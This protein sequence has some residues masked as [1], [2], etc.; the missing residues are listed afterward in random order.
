MNQELT[1]SVELFE[2]RLALMRTLA[3]SL[4]QVQHAVVRSDLRGMDDHT[5]KQREICQALH[6]NSKRGESCPQKLRLNLAEGAVSPEMQRRCRT[7]A[8]ELSEVEMRVSQ[9]NRVYGGLLRRAQRTLQIFQRVLASSANTY[10]PPKCLP[11][12]P[13]SL[14]QEVSHV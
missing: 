14:M 8:E 10:A 13:P 6:R 7:L 12:N 5:A 4:E 9:L 11:A 2:R 1:S 3:S